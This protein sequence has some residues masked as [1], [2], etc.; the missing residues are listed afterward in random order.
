MHQAYL[1]KVE[2]IEAV[3]KPRNGSFWGTGLSKEQ[4]M[5]TRRDM[6]PGQNQLGQVLM[7]VMSHMFDEGDW[8]EP[9]YVSDN[10]HSDHDQPQN[11]NMSVE[12][13]DM[14]GTTEDGEIVNDSSHTEGNNSQA[15]SVVKPKSAGNRQTDKKSQTVKAKGSQAKSRTASRSKS[16]RTKQEKRTNS[17]PN[18]TSQVPKSIKKENVKP[19]IRESRFKLDDKIK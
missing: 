16:P 10:D 4:T 2:L 7:W 1:D 12:G 15:E 19:V 13:Q 5:Y 14:D 8:D 18:T 3:W 9:D 17:S 6:W 11:S